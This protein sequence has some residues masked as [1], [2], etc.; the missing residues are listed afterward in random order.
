MKRPASSPTLATCPHA[1]PTYPR[2]IRRTSY[3]NSSGKMSVKVAPPSAEC[4]GGA[5][6][7]HLYK[8][9]KAELLEFCQNGPQVSGRIWRD[10]VLLVA[11]RQNGKKP[12]LGRGGGFGSRLLFLPRCLLSPGHQE[13]GERAHARQASPPRRCRECQTHYAVHLGERERATRAAFF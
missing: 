2:R 11:F 3:T 10:L 1:P 8:A 9:L 12:L 7:T 6:E 5:Q 4:S 13:G